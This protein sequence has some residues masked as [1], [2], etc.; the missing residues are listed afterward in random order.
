M[1]EVTDAH[2]VADRI[3][4]LVMWARRYATAAISSTAVTT[5]DALRVN[6]PMRVSD[7]ARH[8][9]VS[10]PGM[11]SLVNR[12]EV[13]GQAERVADPADGRVALVRITPLGL[14]VL[15]DRHTARTEGLQGV[16]A[17]LPAGDR[18][19]LVAALPAID[20]LMAAAPPE[21]TERAVPRT[22]ERPKK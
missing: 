7:L 12:L 9:Q 10:Q 11:T 8:E 5:L 22:T 15:A 2:A 16:I 19:A 17:Q 13:A 20:R 18:R 3:G 14:R 6:G 21:P 4:K 1:N